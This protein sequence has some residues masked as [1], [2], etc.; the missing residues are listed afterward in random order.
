MTLQTALSNRFANAFG[1]GVQS[2]R[3]VGL[4]RFPYLTRPSPGVPWGSLVSDSTTFWLRQ[5]QAGN[6]QAAQELW[7]RYY[8]RLIGLARKRLR[9]RR[10]SA[11]VDES[12]IAQ[13]AFASFYRAA[14]QGRFPQLDGSDDLWGLLIVFTR[15][16]VARRLRDECR[17]KRRRLGTAVADAD[18][19]IELEAIASSEPT[20]EFSVAA[21]ESFRLLIGQ[22]S[23]TTLRSLALMKMEGYTNQEIAKRLG[24]SLST[25]E[26]KLRRI[27][28]E[29]SSVVDPS[30]EQPE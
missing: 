22:L 18:G 25:I 5:L 4:S 13:S 20:P 28:H 9:G 29:W 21:V 1:Q 24:C 17:L 11:V 6:R 2:P 27:R 15:R 19:P 16:K 30:W 3:R 10:I 7:E 8:C 12:D 23:N 14:E 26:R